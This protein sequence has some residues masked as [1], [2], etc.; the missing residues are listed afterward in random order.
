MTLSGSTLYGATYRGGA[1]SNG[2]VFGLP[3]SGG[4]IQA[5][6]SFPQ[7]PVVSG[8]GIHP[9]GD[10]TVSGSTIY[11]TTSGGGTN[12]IGYG[13]VFSVPVAGGYRTTLASFNGYDCE[14]TPSGLTLIGG[15]LYG[16][17][18]QGWEP[19]EHAA[20]SSVCLSAAAQQPYWPRSI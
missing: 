7:W 18:V 6:T 14:Q 15:T 20:R 9:Q 13:T 8:D 2:V 17:G 11:G 3:V 10:L 12:G 1:N 16:E 4:A 19:A 5:L